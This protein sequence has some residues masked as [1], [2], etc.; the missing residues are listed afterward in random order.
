MPLDFP[1]SPTV[2]ATYTGPG[3]VVWSW[4]GT[5]WVNGAS[6]TA[7]A[8]IGSPAFTGDPT[9]PTPVY[10]DNDTSVATT[11]FV[12]A[13]VAPMANNVGRNRLHNPRFSINQRTY[14]SGTALAAGAYAH[15]RWK[16]GASGCTYT[17]T[18]S[19][20]GTTITITAGSL[21][22][23]MEAMAVEGGTYTLSWT[24]TAQGRI[25]AGAYAA[26][27]V[28]AAGLAVNTAITTEFNVGTLAGV[29]L[30]IGSV[31]TPL[32]KPDPRYDLSNCQR[33]YQTAS[34]T[35]G[36]YMNI[37]ASGAFHT[38]QFATPMRG[39]PMVTF[40]PTGGANYS[41]VVVSSVSLNSAAVQPTAT[42]AGMTFF[43]YSYT[44]SADL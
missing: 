33:F 16:A 17:F 37:G 26:S 7:F 19:Q 27:P 30:E 12:Q 21:Q 34:G 9:A 1:N 44:A 39:G 28:T 11:A 23:I 18:Q 8:P 4:D 40:T 41:G 38:L 31:A 22:Q 29:Q 15:D 36:G 32:E 24:G 6:T 3:G 10:G 5:K 2:G 42:A 13:A 43:N 25:N 35:W 14:V 20:P